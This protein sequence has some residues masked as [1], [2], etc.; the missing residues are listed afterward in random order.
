MDEKLGSPLLCCMNK[1]VFHTSRLLSS[2]QEEF[3]IVDEF[4]RREAIVLDEHTVQRCHNSF[5]AYSR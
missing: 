5:E 4:P 3:R 1:F 2:L